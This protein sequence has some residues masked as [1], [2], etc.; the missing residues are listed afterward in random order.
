M[1]KKEENCNVCTDFK[2][3]IGK[4][5]Q[6]KKTL[7]QP[8]NADFNSQGVLFNGQSQ[9]AVAYLRTPPDA[10]ELGNAT[11]LFLHTTAAYYAECP[12][13]L[14]KQKMLLFIDGLSEFY[15]CCICSEH[16]KE[17]ISKNPPNVNSNIELS[18]WFCNL[19][20]NV[21]RRNNKPFFDCSKILSSYKP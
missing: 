2:S 6:K 3:A 8:I 10:T 15:P 17:Y 18:Q 21:N 11:W 14:Q 16:L 5:M 1:N 19:H 20:N 4:F 9:V 7:P 13:N 12:T